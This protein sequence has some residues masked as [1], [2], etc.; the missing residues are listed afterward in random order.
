[1]TFTGKYKRNKLYVNLGDTCSYDMLAPGLYS[2]CSCLIFF[3]KF[4]SQWQ[5]M[6]SNLFI[7]SSYVVSLTSG[8]VIFLRFCEQ[9]LFYLFSTGQSEVP[10]EL[11]I[12]YNFLCLI[13]LQSWNS[14]LLNQ[15]SV[16]HLWFSLS[17]W[18]C[19]L[20]SFCIFSARLCAGKT[21][22]CIF[23]KLPALEFCQIVDATV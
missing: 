11:L 6:L 10:A 8:K 7:Y 21:N 2:I 13:D 16:N 1:M 19:I 5:I 17:P 9:I 15:L 20:V 4:I 14:F 3:A 12:R 22:I 18:S 23:V